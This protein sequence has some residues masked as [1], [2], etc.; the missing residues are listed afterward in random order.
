MAF[1]ASISNRRQPPGRSLWACLLLGI[2]LCVL[3]PSHAR[4]Q[5]SG[6]DSATVKVSDLER[7]LATVADDVKRQELMSNLKALIAAQNKPGAPAAEEDDQSLLAGVGTKLR[8]ASSG[9][10]DAVATLSNVSALWAWFDRQIGNPVVLQRWGQIV[11]H[12]AIVLAVG[13]V[14]ERLVM[15]VV[16]RPGRSMAERSSGRPLVRIAFALLRAILLAVPVAAF[17]AASYATL[18][19]LS[20]GT[21]A[22]IAILVILQAYV[23][24]R[25]VMV[26]ARLVLAPTS[27]NLR[28]VPV[29][30]E[31]AHYLYIWAR[32][33]TVVIL[34]GVASIDAAVGLGL[35]MAGAH[36]LQRLLGLLVATMSAVLVL[37]NRR[38]IAGWIRGSGRNE[39][40]GMGSLS[41]LRARI[42]D[43]WHILAILYIAGAFGV[44]A[45]GVP[46]GFMFLLRSSATSVVILIIA[47]LVTLG[48]RRGL[49]RGFAL[50]DD[51]KARFP[52]L[53]ARANRYLPVI[54]TVLRVGV[55]IVTVLALAQAW[56]INSFAWLETPA[57]QRVL[58]AVISIGTVLV[59]ALI[60]WE[61]SNQ[62]IDAYLNRMDGSGKRLE[63]SA[64]ARTLLPLLRNVL[65]IV[66]SVMVTLIVLSELGINIAP[67]LAG[68]GVVGL[69][70]GFGSQKLVQDVI[71]G[72]FILFEDAIAIGDNV[73]VAGKSGSVEALSIRSIR[74]RDGNGGIHT[75]PFS[76]VDMVTNL[77]RD[78]SYFNFDISVSNREDPDRVMEVIAQVGG[79]LKS[80][81]AFGWMITDP[82]EVWGMDRFADSAVTIKGRIR[83]R[84]TKQAAVG[85]A[86]N[87]RLKRRFDELGIH[88]PSP[89]NA[90]Y[91]NFDPAG[92]PQLAQGS[93]G[94]TPQETPPSRIGAPPR[95]DDPGSG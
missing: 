2:V 94:E 26:V 59:F 57:G 93:R 13:L 71:T 1:V 88:P 47:R 41:G 84:P 53:E 77:S 81:P 8:E 70:I 43:V 11:L 74:L 72:V 80:D 69:A 68:A 63:R 35:P 40:F 91:L 50:G 46:G 19:V 10:V 25:L 30:D 75:I 33:L 82:I 76:A 73:D 61:G 6:N 83:T 39:I 49:D 31:T 90:V 58:N 66:L 17:A 29:D 38:Q 56:G 23:I 79:E 12:L 36:G 27:P 67:L 32:R 60:A 86:F 14:A 16:A 95:S 37:Q 64:R 3:A 78:F 44:W 24:G 52:L 18:L 51:V 9:L 87:L 7:L 34:T 22:P 4:A 55:M 5:A 85:R 45:L 20:R 21:T 15:G 42:A 28:L 89:A 62:T 65:M 48:I 54:H 92:Q